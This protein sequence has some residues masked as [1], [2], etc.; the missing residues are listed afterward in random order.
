MNIL[1]TLRIS[2][3]GLTSQR[4][5]LQAISSNLANARSTRTEEGGP[6][7]RRMPVF[8]AVPVDYFGDELEKQ[9]HRVEVIDIEKSEV[10]GKLVYDPN[11]PDANEEGY[12]EYPNVE[13]LHEMV[14]MMTTSRSYESNTIAV[15]TTYR[16]ANAALELG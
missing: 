6:Y 16:M 5:R 15:M 8:Q 3:S 9:L 4:I 2:A 10:P 14:D 13:M 12:V 7:Q 11:H 1:D